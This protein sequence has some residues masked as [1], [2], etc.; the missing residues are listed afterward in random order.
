[1]LTE[2]DKR[3]IIRDVKHPSIYGLGILSGIERLP[4]EDMQVLSANPRLVLAFKAVVVATLMH[5]PID[6]WHRADVEALDAYVNRAL[7]R[8][9][10]RKEL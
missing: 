6:H 5:A 7:A 4:A 10:A 8:A 9:W 1:M 2:H 3:Q